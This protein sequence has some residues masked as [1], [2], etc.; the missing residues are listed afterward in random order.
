MTVAQGALLIGGL[1]LFLLGMGMMTDGLKLAAGRSLRTLLHRWT[2]TRWRGLALGFAIT[3]LVQSSSAVTVAVIGFVNAGL[4]QLSQA[5]W[6]L[7]GSNVGTTMTAWLVAIIGFNIK[8]EALAL[9]MIG[10]GMLARLGGEGT[11]RGSIGIA[12][13]GFGLFFLGIGFLRDAFT[14]V[15]ASF[16]LAGLAAGGLLQDALFVGLGFLITLLTQSSSASIALAL[17]AVA[18]GLLPLEPAAAMVI[19]ANLG[20]TSTGLLAVLGATANAR[21]VAMSHVAFNVLAAVVALVLLPFLV[22]IIEWLRASAR[23]PEGP[24]VVLALFHTVFNVIG[25][26]LVWPLADRMV[27]WLGTRFVSAEEDEARPRHLDPN[28]LVVPVMAVEGLSRELERLGGMSRDLVV[29][30]LIG[31]Q[32]ARQKLEPHHRAV[33][34]LAEAVSGFV[35]QVHA[36]SLSTPTAEAMTHPLRALEHYLDI[37]DRAADFAHGRHLVADLPDTLRTGFEDYAANAAARLRMN[38]MAEATEPGFDVEA[39]YERLKTGL[40]HAASSGA[41]SLS[42]LDA[43][44]DHIAGVRE[45]L[46]RWDRA[47]RRIA[48][49]RA[50]IAEQPE[51]ETPVSA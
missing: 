38:D 28:L 5:I 43:L 50:A 26:L 31:A 23:L 32:A 21:R 46:R 42:D 16:D 36:R 13:A 9:P 41:L 22:Q 20:T 33:T 6:V 29:E 4:L 24:A 19:G 11:Q 45:V 47:A 8:I 34:Q 40:L 1:G 39:A 2:H 44:I 15:A 17:T 14:A 49:M 48:A 18:G 7:F 37:A 12:V 51:R 3:A 30:A 27:A 25:V 10:L 35:Q